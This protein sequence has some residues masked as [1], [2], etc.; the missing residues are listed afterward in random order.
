MPLL[1]AADVFMFSPDAFE[2]IANMLAVSTEAFTKPAE[3]F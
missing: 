3:A 1:K 2:K